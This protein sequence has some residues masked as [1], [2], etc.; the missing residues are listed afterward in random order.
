[1]PV[2]P[3]GLGPVVVGGPMQGPASVGGAGVAPD[4]LGALLVGPHGM[5]GLAPIRPDVC[6]GPDVELVATLFLR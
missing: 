1:M 5:E 2:R 4:H 6:P 3:D